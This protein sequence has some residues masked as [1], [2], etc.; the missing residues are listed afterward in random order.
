MTPQA[1]AERYFAAWNL[2][3]S[4]AIVASLNSEA[5]YTDPTVGTL[6]AAAVGDYA[7]MLYAAFPDLRFEILSIECIGQRVVA[8]WMMYGT[9]HGPYGGGP[10]TG[11]RIALPGIDIVT[12]TEG[13]VS[14]VRGYFDQR[15]VVDQL[16]LQVL[17]QPHTAG[18]FSFGRAVRV[19]SGRGVLP[20]T[21]GLTWLTI[22]DPDEAENMVADSRQIAVDMLGMPGFISWVGVVVGQHFITLTAW[23]DADAVLQLRKGAGH[24]HAMKRFFGQHASSSANTSIWSLE[25]MNTFWLRCP[26]CGTLAD[27]ATGAETC[28][29]GTPLPEQRLFL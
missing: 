4:A 24:N 17:V 20:G 14:S 28:T 12:V 21:L 1:M 7:D 26:A 11:R 13:G 5:T 10:P 16:G 27:A 3:D 29:C 25:R 18:P 6:P 19:H 22:S 9:N 8:E 15:T 23:D 2:H